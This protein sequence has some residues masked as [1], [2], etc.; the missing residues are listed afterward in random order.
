M[1]V[2]GGIEVGAG[3]VVAFAVMGA[4]ASAARQLLQARAS[5]RDMH[6]IMHWFGKISVTW[7]HAAAA[8]SY[9]N[10]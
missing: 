5:T 10:L 4:A 6:C 8:N 9:H 1:L 7:M 2:I 3:E